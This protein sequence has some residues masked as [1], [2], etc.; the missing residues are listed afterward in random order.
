MAVGAL[1]SGPTASADNGDG[2]FSFQMPNGQT[3]T[4]AGQAAAQK[5][6]YL[7]SA[8]PYTVSPDM[9]LPPPPPP[10]EMPTAE[11]TPEQQ[12]VDAAMRS[13]KSAEEA[14]R[15]VRERNSQG[16]GW[17]KVKDWAS[18][19][20]HKADAAGVSSANAERAK[21]G[22]PPVD[23][24]GTTTVENVSPEATGAPVGGGGGAVHPST[25]VGA[26][27][28]GSGNDIPTVITGAPTGVGRVIP[29][30]MAQVGEQTSQTVIPDADRADIKEGAGLKIR[31]AGQLGAAEEKQA[32]A[33]YKQ[34]LDIDAEAERRD[35]MDQ[36]RENERQSFLTDQ[37]Q[38]AQDLINKSQAQKPDGT[39]VVAQGLGVMFGSIAAG[40][41]GAAMGKLGQTGPNPVL[42]QMNRDAELSIEKAKAK[43]EKDKGDIEA[44]RSI[45]GDAMRQFGDERQAAAVQRAAY[46][47]T[48]ARKLDTTIQGAQSPIIR[49]RA[50]AM[51]GSL[52]EERGRAMGDI[53]KISDAKSYAMTKPV[54]VGGGGTAPRPIYAADVK[55]EKLVKTGELDAQG[56]PIF[57]EFG[58]GA[59]AQKAAE[60]LHNVSKS[61]G[62]A[63]ELERI[64]SNPANLLDP[65]MRTR[66]STITARLVENAKG[67]E[68]GPSKPSKE[69]IELLERAHGGD[70]NAALAFG[71]SAGIKEYRHGLA[72]ERQSLLAQ[73]AISTGS[74]WQE[75]DA[76]T[77]QGNFR[78]T[79][80]GFGPNQK[81]DLGESVDQ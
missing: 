28:A 47:D 43:Y 7:Q 79:R 48:A 58:E 61:D 40:L 14:Q 78:Y 20:L 74:G 71:K 34:K 36:A 81:Q 32:D 3:I 27:H 65:K 51:K 31:A 45:Y 60:R 50:E 80:H 63:A 37:R 30:H 42:Q 23:R 38:K 56:H 35:A 6:A 66:V 73:H 70:M 59:T 62:D 4:A 72:A 10:I 53:D 24:Q 2:T 41:T 39:D 22:L 15:Y 5:H 17:N 57:A 76:K 64:A 52:L 26:G 75:V 44:Q 68:D 8:N 77:G 69:S 21:A 19:L 46:F 55:P 13:G 12:Q 1:Y 25:L 33:L 18:G 9:G 11:L 29:G 54:V 16:E 67:A 49:A